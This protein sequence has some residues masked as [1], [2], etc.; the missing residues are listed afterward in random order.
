LLLWV[1]RFV[2]ESIWVT[3]VR[4]L[5]SHLLTCPEFPAIFFSEVTHF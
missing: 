2:D 1:G 4:T 5:D 3:T